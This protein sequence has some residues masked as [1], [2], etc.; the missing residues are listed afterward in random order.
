MPQPR[1]QSEDAVL[2]PFP[3]VT[4]IPGTMHGNSW[5]TRHNRLPSSSSTSQR[6]HSRTQ[7]HPIV[8]P[9]VTNRRASMASFQ[10]QQQRQ[11][12]MSHAPFSRSPPW[13]PL[14]QQEDEEITRTSHQVPHHRRRPE[15]VVK[16]PATIVEHPKMEPSV[17]PAVQ[18]GM[19][20]KSTVSS[21]SSENDAHVILH[22]VIAMAVAV[23]IP[24]LAFSAVPG[25]AGRISIA[26]LVG[27]SA[28]GSVVQSGVVKK[29]GDSNADVVCIAAVYA[30]VMAVVA[31]VIG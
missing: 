12:Q 29:S 5:L 19:A 27:L 24:V 10:L 31:G 3:T 14:K 20:V 8:V 6:G 17:S 30:A 23:L 21:S 16:E 4:P 7:S 13:S 22:V 25:F 15:T 2:P 1:E 26:L 28:M 9:R 11:R 18:E